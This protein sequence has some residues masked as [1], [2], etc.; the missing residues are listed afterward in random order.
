MKL[1]V[2]GDSFSY[3][4]RV[5]YSWPT[6]LSQIYKVDNLSQCGCSEYKI[7][8]Q[9]A[10]RDLADYDAVLIFHTSPNRIYY[11]RPNTMHS[12]KFHKDSDLLFADVEHH[13]HTTSLAQTAYDY[14]LN[15][16]DAE[17]Y[18]Y[19]HNLICADIDRETKQHKTHHFTAFDY[20]EL[21]QFDNSLLDLYNIWNTNRG[22][23]NHLGPVG[24]DEFFLKINSLLLA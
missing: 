10:S 15:I 2:C 11:N 8:L 17:H 7:R 9:I 18:S 24:H 4:H 23:V 14:F 21:Y 5:D 13:R 20:S 22:D 19:V 3:D 6:R 16:F 12:D 1:L